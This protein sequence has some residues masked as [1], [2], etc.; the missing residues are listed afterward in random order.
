MITNDTYM[1]GFPHMGKTELKNEIRERYKKADSGE[2]LSGLAN[3]I[4]EVLSRHADAISDVTYSYRICASDTCYT[5]A[6]SINR[7]VLTEMSE[8]DEADVTVTGTEA[9]LLAVFRR[10]VSPM[11]AMLRG[12]VKVKGSMPALVRFAEFL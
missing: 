6:F 5:R 2:T 10:Q 3:G 7:G 12:K 1:E 8:M 4:C 11:S 9:N